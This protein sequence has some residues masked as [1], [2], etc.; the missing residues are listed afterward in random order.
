MS[1][2]STAKSLDRLGQSAHAYRYEGEPTGWV[3]QQRGCTGPERPLNP[4]CGEV[5]SEE[6]VDRA[7]RHAS[8]VDADHLAAA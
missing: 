6:A 4:S 8:L 1:H 5:H 7:A 2:V 3:K